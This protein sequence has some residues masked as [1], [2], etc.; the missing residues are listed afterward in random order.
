MEMSLAA[1]FLAF[2]GIWALGFPIHDTQEW[3]HGLEKRMVKGSESAEWRKLEKSLEWIKD[4]MNN[5]DAMIDDEAKIR[6]MQASGRSCYLCAFGVAGEKK[7]PDTFVRRFMGSIR[8]QGNE[9]KQEGDKTVVTYKWGRNHQNPQGLILHDGYCMCPIVETGP[10]EL[11]PT[12]CFCSTGYVKEMFERYTGK[13]VEKIELLDSL[14][15]GGNDCIFRM[16]IV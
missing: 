11:S 8:L 9:V 3:I 4:M 10:P 13:T 6:L 1:P 5:M 7:P 15:M 16:E 12:F 2:P 14:K